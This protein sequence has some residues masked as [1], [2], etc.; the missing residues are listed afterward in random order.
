[1]AVHVTAGVLK[2]FVDE[3]GDGGL[4]TG[5]VERSGQCPD[6]AGR[7]AEAVARERIGLELDAAAHVDVGAGRPGDYRRLGRRPVECSL[8]EPYQA[9]LRV[10]L[11]GVGFRGDRAK[12]HGT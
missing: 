11:A 7:A 5:C 12:T 10:E 9:V 4:H 1:M 8:D 2:G 6:R 3:I